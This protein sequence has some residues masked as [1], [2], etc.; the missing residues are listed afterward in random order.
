M[1]PSDLFRCRVRRRRLSTAFLRASRD[2]PV[3]PCVLVGPPWVQV[4]LLKRLDEFT[5]RLPDAARAALPRPTRAGAASPSERTPTDAAAA[6][7][8]GAAAA[9]AP[10]RPEGAEQGGDM[11]EGSDEGLDARALNGGAAAV[12][13]PGSQAEG[14]AAQGR[15]AAAA[16]DGGPWMVQVLAPHAKALK[17]ALKACGWLD[18][19]RLGGELSH[20]DI[21]QKVAEWEAQHGRDTLRE[22]GAAHA[23][24]HAANGGAEQG[25]GADAAAAEGNGGGGGAGAA[26]SR[27]AWV[28]LPIHAAAAQPLQRAIDALSLSSSAAA[29]HGA[30][31]G[32][33]AAAAEQLSGVPEGVLS[34]LRPPALATVNGALGSLE[35]AAQP[36]AAATPGKER[37]E[38]ARRPQRVGVGVRRLDL[39]PSGAVLRGGLAG[40]MRQAVR[41]L[42]EREGAPPDVAEALLEDL[43]R[44]WGQVRASASSAR[45]LAAQRHASKTR[46]QRNSHAAQ[47]S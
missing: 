24:A 22:N 28:V 42:L 23:P 38:E 32:D 46:E 18:V 16:A 19:E 21:Q 4:R 36:A 17:D 3:P 45:R 34:A 47:G 15:R 5:Q 11:D 35:D 25:A 43:P 10:W 37:E 14:G 6:A 41:R 39:G 30:G 2:S 27:V 8:A 26:P 44:R 33:D 31:S 7:A 29:P 9:P 13:P 20:P 1:L 12:A 40:R